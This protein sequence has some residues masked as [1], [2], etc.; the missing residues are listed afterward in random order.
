MLVDQMR[1]LVVLVLLVVVVALSCLVPVLDASSGDAQPTYRFASSFSYTSYYVTVLA[2]LFD[3][4]YFTRLNYRD[5]DLTE[6]LDY[7]SAVALLG[8]SLIVAITRCFSVRT[9]AARVM[10]AAPLLAFITTHILYLN[11]Y[12]LD[13][14]WNM[15]V[16]VVMA[17]AQ[18]LLWAVWAGVTRHPSRWKVWMVVFVGG[19][20]MLLEIF[21]FPPYNG[22]LDAHALWHFFTVP[23][24][25]VWWS[26]IS[27]DVRFRTATFQKKAK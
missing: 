14:G 22:F 6:K 5:V 24:T 21:D 16:C 12:K 7:S 26:F 1:N 27:D 4:H 18:L 10:A 11:I 17:V 13:Y 23:L 2:L 8:G 9:E 25:C 19:L 15:S 3:S 20:A